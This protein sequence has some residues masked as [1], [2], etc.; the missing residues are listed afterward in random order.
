MGK[1]IL[2]S[3]VAHLVVVALIFLIPAGSR[4]EHVPGKTY[5]VS[6]V[7]LAAPPPAKKVTATRGTRP[8]KRKTAE[9]KKTDTVKKTK[10]LKKA[11]PK[12]APSAK[13]KSPPAPPPEKKVEL[14]QK[15]E[16]A[17]N[18]EKKTPKERT[19]KE[20]KTS[21]KKEDKGKERS[22]KDE[23]AGKVKP[24]K[25]LS[26]AGATAAKAGPSG[27]GK[28]SLEDVDFPFSYYLAIMQKKISQRWRPEYGRAAGKGKN[29][30]VVYFRILRDG[31][32]KDIKLEKSSGD[33]SLDRSS[34]N[35]IR[36]AGPMP[37]LPHE[38]DGE[39]LRIHFGFEFSEQG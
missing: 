15:P 39:E 27:V 35:A 34:V 2:Y 37:P 12:P 11:I 16:K 24:G 26:E 18:E 30:V 31:S 1:L 19:A 36:E 14:K 10:A 32:I 25:A 21:S 29:R 4:I 23:P 6:F 17:P 28:I 8:S 13:K 7:E 22:V 20:L 9:S 33:R 5:R 3:L 38:F